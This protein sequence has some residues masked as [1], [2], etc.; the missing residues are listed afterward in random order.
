MN[1]IAGGETMEVCDE[2][3]AP[4]EAVADPNISGVP[5]TVEASSMDSFVPDAE[6]E[7][8]AAAGFGPEAEVGL[9]R[10]KVWRFTEPVVGAQTLRP[11]LTFAPQIGTTDCARVAST[12]KNPARAAAKRICAQGVRD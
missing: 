3:D 1:A 6:A 8:E 7:S 2:P 4:G 9:A 12:Q 10:D 5:T 11:V